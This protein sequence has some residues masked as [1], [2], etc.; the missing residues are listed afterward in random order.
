MNV[1]NISLISEF[2]NIEDEKSVS[3]FDS[4]ADYQW[5]SLAMVVIQTHFSDVADIEIDP[6]ILEK[7]ET[8]GELD[9]FITKNL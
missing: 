9:N 2:L 3:S 4:L 1:V 6:D 7:L 8:I 5:D